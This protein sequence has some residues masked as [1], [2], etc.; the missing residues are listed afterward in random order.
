MTFRFL[1]PVSCPRFVR[2][3]AFA[4]LSAVLVA[5]LIAMTSPSGAH[6]DTGETMAAGTTKPWPRVTARSDVHELVGV[7]KGDRLT[8]YIDQF[9]NN[10]PIIDAV[11]LVT[12][13][14]DERL[15]AE[16]QPDGTYVV[17]SNRFG[18]T[19][20]L[21]LSIS[22][23]A[24]S[25]DDLLMGTL[26]LPENG[27]SSSGADSSRTTQWARWSAF[28]PPAI[29]N[30]ALLS[31]V[32]FLLGILA[33]HFF[34]SGRLIP[35]TV[36]AAG[37]VGVCVLLIGTAL[38]LGELN[39]AAGDAVPGSAAMSDAP[40]RRP[41]G[42]V[43]LAKPTQRL[44][45]IRTT[46]ARQETVQRAINLIGRVIAEPNRTS[47][48]QSIGGGRVI[49]PDTGL[50]HVGQVITKGDLLAEIERPLQQAERT[51]IS[52][53]TGEIEQLVA[54]TEAKL[55][56]LRQLAERG[57]V[58][59]R[60]AVEA[61][62]E[63]EGLRRRREVIQETRIDREVL[64]APTSGIITVAKVVPGQVVQPQDVM[65]QIIDPNGL[66]VEALVYGGVMPDALGSA[67]IV[68]SDGDSI[69]L[70]YQGFSRALQQQAILVHFSI[71]H[72]LANLNIGQPVTVVAK[73]GGTISGIV[74]PRDAVVRSS[75]GETIA[76]LHDEFEDFDPKPVRTQPL[77]ATR[78]I[79]VAGVTEGERIVIR[80]ADLVNQIR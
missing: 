13:A 77:D 6:E 54:V 5:A 49:A 68:T 61:A 59:Q 80:G 47:L 58:P 16:A 21:N 28:I 71:P 41:D 78:V 17:S 42:G 20:Q 10:E 62:L 79:I 70:V 34:R 24:K 31:F 26:Q 25:G 53:K 37:A 9:P 57:L 18:A 48:V 2:C 4:F 56:R 72:P 67:S 22:V 76:W 43:F 52:E 27:T 64:R 50:P 14:Q 73:T 60:L 66:W 12:I 1:S 75:N 65:F 45:E 19:G 23:T 29:Q 30:P 38:G 15:H 63:L 35:A 3:S 39:T 51:T 33:G 69:E 55:K 11:V 7:L 32:S 44:L 36:T 8:I 46:V 74:M 40:R